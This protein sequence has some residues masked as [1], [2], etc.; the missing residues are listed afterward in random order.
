MTVTVKAGVAEDGRQLFRKIINPMSK[1]CKVDTR[2]QHPDCQQCIWRS[3]EEGQPHG[4][5]P[6]REEF[7]QDILALAE[8]GLSA[9]EIATGVL[10]DNGY[11]FTIGSVERFLVTHPVASDAR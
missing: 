5:T 1:T 6:D 9:K 3:L 10:K 4:V 11:R 7:H 8:M 2:S